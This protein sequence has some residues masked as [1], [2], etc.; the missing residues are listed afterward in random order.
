MGAAQF[1]E[2]VR[3][4]DQPL[5]AA[6]V[7]CRTPLGNLHAGVLHHD[8]QSSVFSLSLGWEDKL[9]DVWQWQMLWAAPDVDPA[10]LFSVAAM[11]RLIKKEFDQSRRFPYRFK[12]SGTTF[13]DS[14]RLRFGLGAQGLTCATFILA[15]FESV[16]VRIVD[17]GDWPVRTADDQRYLDEFVSKHATP[18]HL[19]IL[20]AEVN[21]GCKRIRPEEVLGACDCPLPAKF[22]PTAASAQRVIDK[23]D[24]P[25]PPR[26]PPAAGDST[27]ELGEGKAS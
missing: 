15:V 23:L 7:I 1:D 22:T 13:D 17:E 14:G 10:M 8:G 9:L 12:Y 25:R 2:D 4:I 16:R 11:C 20:Q 6:A 27:Q 24:A 18:E 21:A 3:F 5:R 19:A 26:S